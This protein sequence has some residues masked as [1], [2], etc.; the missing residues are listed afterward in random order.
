MDIY[1]VSV[2]FWF[3]TSFSDNEKPNPMSLTVFTHWVSLPVCN[4]YSNDTVT[5][6]HTRHI[7]CPCP[8]TLGWTSS[9][10]N[11]PTTSYA[12]TDILSLDAFP[13]GWHSYS[14]L[15]QI[16]V[17]HHLAHRCPPYPSGGLTLHPRWS[18][19]AFLDSDME[20]EAT[21]P[22]HL[23][24]IHEDS[25]LISGHLIP[26]HHH[27]A[28]SLPRSSSGYLPCSPSSDN[29]DHF[30]SER[31]T[32]FNLIMRKVRLISSSWKQPEST[33]PFCVLA[34]TISYLFTSPNHCASIKVSF[35]SEDVRTGQNLGILI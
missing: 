18:S 21:P 14:S 34:Y 28:H 31:A 11:H 12:F 30:T 3:A 25:P 8:C 6:Q 26:G 2:A 5:C 10:T 15:A 17:A 22:P 9:P 4:K 32:M 7:S 16:L 35:V 29:L 19:I 27:A 23:M 24:L 20:Q 1:L 13:Y 33:F